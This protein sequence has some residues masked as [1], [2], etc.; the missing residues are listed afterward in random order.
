MINLLNIVDNLDQNII[1]SLEQFT[2]SEGEILSLNDLVG[3]GTYTY[4]LEDYAG[5][6]T[7][8]VININNG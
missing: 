6:V 7:S 3:V 2:Y 1:F 4:T 5:N 8:I